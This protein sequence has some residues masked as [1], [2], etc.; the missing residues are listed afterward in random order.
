MGGSDEDRRAIGLEIVDAVRDGDALSEGT[1]VVV[2]HGNGLTAPGGPSVFEASDQLSLLRVDADDGIAAQGEAF[3]ELG[4]VGELL[5]AIR[6]RT[7]GELLV[8]DA[9]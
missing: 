6:L 5:V 7:I 4:D 9:E 3:T 2:I 1:E 8:V